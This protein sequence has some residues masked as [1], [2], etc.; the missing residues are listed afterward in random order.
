MG[1]MRNTYRI[2]GE[3]PDGKI[4]LVTYC[5]RREDIKVVLKDIEC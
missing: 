4:L 5:R 3:K 2:L 1:D